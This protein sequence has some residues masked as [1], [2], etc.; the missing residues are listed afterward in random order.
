[1]DLNIFDGFQAIGITILIKADVT[2]LLSMGI[3]GELLC[4]FDVT[5]HI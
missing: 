4:P 3:S 5:L 1:M 2:P